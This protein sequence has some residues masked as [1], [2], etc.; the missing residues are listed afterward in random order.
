ME[1]IKTYMTIIDSNLLNQIQGKPKELVNA[2]KAFNFISEEPLVNKFCKGKRPRK[3][4]FNLK[5]RTLKILQAFAIIS[6]SRDA[7]LMKRKS[8]LCRRNFTMAKKFLAKGERKEGL[9]LIKQ[10]HSIA[11]EYD[12]AHF[13]SETASILYHN[14]I[15]YYPSKRKAIFYA[16]QMQKYLK[17]NTAEK[18]AEYYYYQAI[19]SVQGDLQPD[20]F[21]EYL[22]EINKLK[23]N[24]IKYYFYKHRMEV[25]YL[26]QITDYKSVITECEKALQYF[27]DKKGIYSSYYLFFHRTMGKVQM[28]IGRYETA[29]TS[30]KKA[31][32]YVVKRSLSDYILRLYQTLNA[33]HSKQYQEAYD[34]YRKNRRCR[35]AMVKDQFAIIEAYMCYLSH[36]GYLELDRIF[37]LGKYLNET[38]KAQ[39]DKQGANITILIAELLVYLARDRGK[40]IDRV[41]AVRHYTYRHL[42]TKELQRAKHFIKVLCLLPRANFHPVALQRV[43]HTHITYLKEHPIAMGENVAVEIIPFGVLLEMIMQQLVQKTG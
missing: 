27:K 29:H 23:G 24:G 40:F 3:Y 32:K 8:D 14:H 18:M 1:S 26:L 28:A 17:Q 4:Y 31:E 13:A 35:F 30:F 42:K 9:S 37:R 11:V 15:Y 25:D 16:E 36:M 12:I 41:E 21:K 33:L 5:S 34:L 10:A 39:S 7:S 6:D 2:I 38:F 20:K 19:S 43:A 22:I